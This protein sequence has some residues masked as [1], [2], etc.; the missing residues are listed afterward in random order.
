MNRLSA[1]Q[2]I[3]LEQEDTLV[4]V[5]YAPP[6]GT[7]IEVVAGYAW[8]GEGGNLDCIWQFV[9]GVTVTNLDGWAVLAS[10]A[11]RHLYARVPSALPLIIRYG[12][13]LRFVAN[14]KTITKIAYMV[15]VIDEYVG[16]TP[17]G[18]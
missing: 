16:E 11:Y 9:D 15:L 4:Y 2:R 14:L 8:H 6:I 5:E 3:L 18:H 17:Y 1:R 7:A 10:G 12:Q 13:R